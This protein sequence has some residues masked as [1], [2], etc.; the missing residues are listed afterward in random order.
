MLGPANKGGGTLSLM[1]EKLCPKLRAFIKNIDS[2]FS[3]QAP[4]VSPVGPPKDAFA[5]ARGG[6]VLTQPGEGA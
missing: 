5:K 1:A 4:W 3:P 2:R 6:A